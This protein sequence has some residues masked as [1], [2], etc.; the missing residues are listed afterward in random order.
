ML[1][2]LLGL[3]LSFRASLVTVLMSFAITGAVLGAFSP[4]ALFIVWNCPAMNPDLSLSGGAY[5][6]ILLMHVALIAI[7]GA[8]GTFRLG[9]LLRSLSPSPAV[10]RRVLIA[11]LAANLFLGSQLSWLLRP[12]IGSPTLPVHFIRAT[13]FQGNFYEAVIG[14]LMRVLH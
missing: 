5:N 7:A 2:P 12:F 3:R 11:W 8:A 9:Q 14:S 13:A 6:F 4:L 10:A 1:A